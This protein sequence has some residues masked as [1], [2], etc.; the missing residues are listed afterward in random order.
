MSLTDAQWAR[1]EPLLPDRA[2][3]RGG[4]WRDHRQ[5]I[6][7]IAFKYSTGTPWTELPGQFGS[8]K[9]AHGCGSGLPTAPGSVCSPPCSSRP[10]PKATSTGS[11]CRTPHRRHLHLVGEMTRRKRPRPTPVPPVPVRRSQR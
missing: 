4:R 10:T 6:D 11:S 1:I 5:A 8:W 3:K 9:G 2:P 7:A